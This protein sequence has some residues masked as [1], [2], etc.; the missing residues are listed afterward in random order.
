VR[1]G[2]RPTI[3]SFPYYDGARK[4]CSENIL[5]RELQIPLTALAG[6][7]AESTTG[8]IRICAAPVRMVQ[9][10]E[11]LEAKLKPLDLSDREVLSQTHIPINEARIAQLLRGCTPKVP[12]AGRA[13]ASLLNQ[14]AELLNAVV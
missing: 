8:R 7:Q 2:G 9:Q 4:R 6:H 14:T 5:K 1:T 12:G 13:N 10:I 11:N 3:I